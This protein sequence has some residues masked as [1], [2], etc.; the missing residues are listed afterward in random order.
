M[1]TKKKECKV[2]IVSISLNFRN[3]N[4][5]LSFEEILK[6]PEILKQEKIINNKSIN[7]DILEE[8]EEYV[9]GFLRATIDKDLPPKIDKNTKEMSAID[10]K[11]SEGLAY[12]SVFLYSIKLKTLFYEINQNTIYIDAFRKFIIKCYLESR[13]LKNITSF[14]II[15]S[16]I[17][18]KKE[19]ER[20][21]KMDFYKSFKMKV[22]HPKKLYEEWLRLSGNLEHNIE[23]DFLPEIKKGAELNS[24][25]AE[26]LY[27]V[28]NPKKNGGLYKEKIEPLIKQFGKILGYGQIREYLD[29]IEIC[30]YTQDSSSVKTP[31]DL[32]GDVYRSKFKLDVPRIDSD[33]QKEKRTTSIK[34]VY[35]SEATVLETYI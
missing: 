10:V 28:S 9:I 30:G 7:F 6:H 4:Q 17:Y 3:E 14:D 11:P 24:D 20:A 5:K 29:V 34:N 31:I 22:H 15:I 16:T 27:N 25:F 35:V 18:R 23:M 32:L 8:N 26:I 2:D 19:Y 21:L 1:Q 12:G 33:L 13:E